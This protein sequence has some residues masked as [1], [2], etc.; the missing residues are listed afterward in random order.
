MK[1]RQFFVNKNATNLV[2]IGT[3]NVFLVSVVGMKTH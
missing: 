1:K 2:K 3:G